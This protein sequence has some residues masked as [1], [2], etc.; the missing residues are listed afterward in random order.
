MIANLWYW[1]TGFCRH[2]WELQLKQRVLYDGKYMADMYTMQCKS[3]GKIKKQ[4]K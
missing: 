1:L 3:C 4:E 2:S